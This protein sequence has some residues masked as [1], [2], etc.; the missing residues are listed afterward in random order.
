MMKSNW[1]N[2]IGWLL[3]LGFAVADGFAL[4][5]LWKTATER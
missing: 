3:I 2:I 1:G 4:L 5:L